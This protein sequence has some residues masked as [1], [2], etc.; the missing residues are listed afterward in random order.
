MTGNQSIFDFGYEITQVSN[1]IYRIEVNG[2]ATQSID[3]VRNTALLQA[4]EK[5][6]ESGYTKFHIIGGDGFKLVT[7]TLKAGPI[8]LPITKEPRGNITVKFLGI[9]EPSDED[10]YDA[11]NEILRLSAI[12]DLQKS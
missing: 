12:S 7:R 11:A 8:P 3:E 4:A 10:T 6:I 9:D 1:L 2:P 5:T